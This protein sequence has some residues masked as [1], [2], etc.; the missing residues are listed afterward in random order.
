MREIDPILDALWTDIDTLQAEMGRPDLV[1]FTGDLVQQGDLE[2]DFDLAISRFILPLEEITGLGEDRIF[3]VAGNHDVSRSKVSVPMLERWNKLRDDGVDA[4]REYLGELKEP[5][6]ALATVLSLADM[7]HPRWVHPLTYTAVLPLKGIRLGI[8]GVTSP[9]ASASQREHGRL[10]LGDLQLEMAERELR[11]TDVKIA[12][13]HH[14]VEWLLDEDRQAVEVALATYSIVLNGHLHQV[15]EKTILRQD[16]Q[17]VY[18]SAGAVYAPRNPSLDG[19]TWLQLDWPESVTLNLREYSRSRK[20]FVKAESWAAG[21]QVTRSLRSHSAALMLWPRAEDVTRALDERDRMIPTLRSIFP[22]AN[23]TLPELFV[24]PE[25]QTP[26]AYV[27]G[28]LHTPRDYAKLDDVL[29]GNFNIAF[30]GDAESGKTTL[31]KYLAVRA[32]ED[33]RLPVFVDFEK[34]ARTKLSSVLDR[35]SSWFGGHVSRQA[36]EAALSN[37]TAWILV[38]N[39]DGSNKAGMQ[40]LQEMAKRWPQ[41]RWFVTMRE[42]IWQSVGLRS[43]PEMEII[44]EAYYLR[45][46]TRGKIREFVERFFTLQ[47]LPS[48]PNASTATSQ[49]VEHLGETGFARTPYNLIVLLTL[50]GSQ[51]EANPINEAAFLR[52]YMELVLERGAA[53]E[54]RIGSYTF[55]DK[56]SFLA[57]VAESLLDHHGLM[58]EDQFEVLLTEWHQHFGYLVR[59]SRFDRLFFEKGVLVVEGGRVS[60]RDH[61]I[62]SYYLAVRATKNSCLLDRLMDAAHIQ[63]FGD[64]LTLYAGLRHDAAFLV[65]HVER[66]LLHALDECVRDLPAFTIGNL[67]PQLPF[68]REDLDGLVVQLRQRPTEDAD[69]AADEIEARLQ[70]SR[71]GDGKDAPELPSELHNLLGLHLLYGRLLRNTPEMDVDRKIAGLKLYVTAGTVAWIILGTTVQKYLDDGVITAEWL[72]VEQ[73]GRFVELVGRIARILVPLVVQRVM[74]GR[75]A[76]PKLHSILQML[77]DERVPDDAGELSRFMLFGLL[78]DLGTDSRIDVVRA[79]IHSAPDDLVEL[80]MYKLLGVVASP[81]VDEQEKTR[82]TPLIVEASK[83]SQVLSVQQQDVLR[84]ELRR[85]VLMD[86]VRALDSHNTES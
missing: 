5:P 75:V 1:C 39:V 73:R 26:E 10:M 57:V 56:E 83:R 62:W 53:D 66:L 30:V 32:L 19:Y 40:V 9:W 36:V 6:A 7:A 43:L 24:A 16:R 63:E 50:L 11:A 21:G 3:I 70:A 67:A 47:L 37:G 4:I 13:F 49:L 82:V 51:P 12:L 55:D 81:D 2:A 61:R 52:R 68:R 45:P 38:D 85:Q 80:A 18:S 22:T 29:K 65:E 8:A 74:A 69:E 64:V 44:F 46:I 41:N 76:T 33:Q 15:G 79:F 20:Q 72:P 17:T 54:A 23:I 27:E 42:G 34:V 84:N 71:D 59:K 25:L 48:W 14:P 28:N 35:S 78:Y 77:W 31:L 60:F 86:R 58:A